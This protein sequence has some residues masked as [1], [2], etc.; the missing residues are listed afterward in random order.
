MNSKSIPAKYLKK[1][2]K[3]F[4]S[5][6]K[7]A[8]K[9]DYFQGLDIQKPEVMSPMEMEL[10]IQADRVMFSLN[11][12]VS[13]LNVMAHLPYLLENEGR[14]LKE[15]LSEIEMDFL[16]HVLKAYGSSPIAEDTLDNLK[17]NN[18]IFDTINNIKLGKK[19][20]P[21]AEEIDSNLLQ[22]INMIFANKCIR[23]E[24]ANAKNPVKMP[25]LVQFIND[26]EE[27]K[28]MAKIKLYITGTEEEERYRKLRKAFKSNLMLTA[29]IKDLEQQL[30]VQREQLGSELKKKM[31]VFERYNKKIAKIKEEFQ[32]SIE[33]T[34][35]ESERKMMQ[36]SL[37]SEEKQAILSLEA[38]AIADQ[39]SQ[40]LVDHLDDEKI[41]RARTMKI[42]SQLQSWV[43]KYDQDMTEKQAEY[44][45]I[46]AQYDS[47]KTAMDEM[48]EKMEEQSSLY[49]TLMAEKKEE[50]ERLFQELAFK[51]L[52]NRSARIIQRAWR[53]YRERKAKR[54]HRKG[55]KSKDKAKLVYTKKDNPNAILENKYKGDLFEAMKNPNA[56]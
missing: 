30:N 26:F 29:A 46:K 14:I 2:P 56:F 36:Q 38:K 9:N 49:N 8:D 22:V 37:E 52:M 53:G 19:K 17:I 4:N 33:K 55:K 44:E 32:I 54:R 16:M 42:H 24:I 7:N 47:E 23:F 10:Q 34:I 51:M 43:V 20:F 45:E 6:I 28:A 27:L 25:Y 1:T 18:E 48:E 50:E 13:V 40:L 12:T 11:K 3:P 21:T 15:H 35:D 39:Y 5:I 41:L 31:E